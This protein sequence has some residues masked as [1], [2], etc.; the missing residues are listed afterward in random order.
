MK[1]QL[2]VIV[3]LFLTNSVSAQI[4]PTARYLERI[5][6]CGGLDSLYVL[7]G[8][9]KKIEDDVVFPDKS[10]VKSDIKLINQKIDSIYQ[11]IKQSVIDFT[12]VMPR[13][14]RSI[15]GDAYLPNGAIPYS[16]TSLFFEYGCNPIE[17]KMVLYDETSS[18]VN[19]FVNKLQYFF[20]F[21]G[22]WTIDSEGKEKNVYMLPPV[23][24]EWK[25]FKVSRGKFMAS[26]PGKVLC[27]ILVMGRNGKQP[28]RSLT[29]AQYLLGLRN[30][31]EAHLQKAKVGSSGESID[32]ENLKM[33]NSYLNAVDKS[34]L[35]QPA[36]IDPTFGV[37]GFKGKFGEEKSG[38]FRLVIAATNNNYFDASM[39][40]DVPQLIEIMW[41]YS[42]TSPVE[43]S[44]IDQFEKNFPLEKL[45]AMLDKN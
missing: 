2:L 1:N 45:Q 37:F 10:L 12:G 35:N 44:M 33:I 15:R 40:R 43:K 7:K 11:L 17:K 39:P 6:P 9:W 34:E 32:R 23:E 21:I 29:Q 4:V 38:G 24:G 8:S 18:Q 13:W 41:T 28:W 14:Y 22:K 30:Y 31:Y 5:A 3:I 42:Q 19:I 36:I 25:G 27:K 26:I 20:E 16:C